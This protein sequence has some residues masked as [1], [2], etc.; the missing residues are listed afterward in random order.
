M[1]DLNGEIVKVKAIKTLE[2]AKYIELYNRYDRTDD[3]GNVI[4]DRY[5]LAKY[6]N[7]AI[8]AKAFKYIVKNVIAE[9]YTPIMDMGAS[10]YI[11]VLTR[12]TLAAQQI[13]NGVIKLGY[14][15]KNAYGLKEIDSKG[16]DV[17]DFSN[18]NF[19]N[20]TF[21]TGFE[22]SYTKHMKSDF[23]YILFRFISD[24]DCD[25]CVYS[26]TVEYKINRLNKGV[27]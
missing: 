2:G 17:F 19:G 26:L 16:L 12:M 10:D 24:N 15:T 8:D 4:E 13:T 5:I 20:F 21:N 22:S 11:K 23:N 3:D 1:C 18:L 6:N 27:W 9:W 14:E 7:A 25:C